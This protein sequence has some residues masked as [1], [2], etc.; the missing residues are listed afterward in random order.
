MF[1]PA[2]RPYFKRAGNTPTAA[3]SPKRPNVILQDRPS[4]GGLEGVPRP[5]YHG[6]WAA[7]PGPP[8]SPQEDRREYPT[9]GLLPL[10]PGTFLGA[11]QQAWG[12]PWP[13]VEGTGLEQDPTPCPEGGLGGHG[14]QTP[15]LRHCL[16]LRE[17]GRLWGAPSSLSSGPG[18]PPPEA[19]CPA[20]SP[21]DLQ[22]SCLEQGAAL[23]QRELRGGIP[24]ISQ[25]NGGAHSR[26]PDACPGWGLSALPGVSGW[27]WGQGRAAGASPGD[28]TFPGGGPGRGLGAKAKVGKGGMS[29]MGS[30]EAGGEAAPE[31]GSLP[32]A[33]AQHSHRLSLPRAGRRSCFLV[34]LLQ[35]LP[36]PP[37][38]GTGQARALGPVPLGLS[39]PHTPVNPSH[40]E[41]GNCERDVV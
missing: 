39:P 29:G 28:A 27:A 10:P 26:I 31:G 37:T 12:A 13:S 40:S 30:T 17:G 1:P 38:Q 41:R 14:V 15:I 34:C 22:G 36:Q 4:G 5:C 19:S 25:Q 20:C 16:G 35:S 24:G 7:L 23:G 11:T 2:G 6:S 32:E 9:A 18:L 3:M 8:V 21:W 33:P